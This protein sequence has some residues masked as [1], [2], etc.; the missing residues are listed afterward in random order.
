MWRSQCA[1]KLNARNCW[2]QK[3][4]P[5]C[6]QLSKWHV[7]RPNQGLSSLTPGDG[8]MEIERPWERGC[9]SC[10]NYN[11]TIS[12]VKFDGNFPCD[13]QELV[14]FCPAMRNF[15]YL[16]VFYHW[17]VA[18]DSSFNNAQRL[19]EESVSFLYLLWH[20]AWQFVSELGS[21]VYSLL[22]TPPNMLG[23]ER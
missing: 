5:W 1:T 19:W 23:S 13:Y 15:F 2:L 9:W 11:I 22:D 18:H 12:K 20:I 8:K 10:W 7:T 6:S 4:P 16:I 17:P 21:L 14:K 3:T